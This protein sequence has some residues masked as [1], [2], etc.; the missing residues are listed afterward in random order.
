MFTSIKKFGIKFFLLY[1][2]TSYKL[3]ILVIYPR[4]SVENNGCESI[5]YY[6]I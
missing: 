5:R 6:E 2:Q 4:K 1:I 3:K